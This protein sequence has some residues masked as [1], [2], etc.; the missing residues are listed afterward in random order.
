MPRSAKEVWFIN[1]GLVILRPKE[2]FVQWVQASDLGESAVDAEFVRSHVNGYLIPELDGEQESWDWIRR[3][4]R[5]LFEF[6]LS[7]WYTDESLW[8]K[9]RTWTSLQEWFDVEFIEMVWDMVDT[10][11]TSDPTDP[12]HQL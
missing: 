7:E 4:A 1:R 12:E 5:E 2:P 3:N 6:E 10:V 11:L 9:R 8:P